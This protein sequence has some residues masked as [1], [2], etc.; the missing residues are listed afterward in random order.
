VK[1]DNMT[2]IELDQLRDKSIEQLV[3]LQDKLFSSTVQK[4]FEDKATPQEK[5][6]YKNKVIELSNLIDDLDNVRIN[7]IA[8]LLEQNEAD[9]KT[10][11]ADLST[12]LQG[13]QNTNTT[14]D[15][16]GTLIGTIGNILSI[17]V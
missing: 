12:T 16:L 1:K 10:G 11:I 3:E 15:Q 13:L 5:I 7:K 2:I 6:E 8:D 9:L 14:L 4:F 17:I